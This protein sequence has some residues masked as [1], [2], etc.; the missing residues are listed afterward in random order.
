MDEANLEEA[1]VALVRGAAA[2]VLSG[3]HDGAAL[4]LAQ[5]V[6]EREAALP[7]NAR[8]PPQRVH[9]SHAEA[10]HE[11]SNGYSWIAAL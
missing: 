5:V 6:R 7:P 11:S 4:Q 8:E 3:S 1:V 10:A 9:E 2:V